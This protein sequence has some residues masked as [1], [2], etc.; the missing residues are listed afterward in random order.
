MNIKSYDCRIK[1]ILY[2]YLVLNGGGEFSM[3]L[4]EIFSSKKKFYLHKLNELGASNDGFLEYLNIM[5]ED[6]QKKPNLIRIYDDIKIQIFNT[7][8]NLI[9]NNIEIE[10]KLSLINDLIYITN[11]IYENLEETSKELESYEK[12]IF[13]NSTSLVVDI[14]ESY[15]FSFIEKDITVLEIIHTL[16]LNLN[17]MAET[18]NSVEELFKFGRGKY[19]V[20]NLQENI[21]KSIENIILNKPN[22]ERIGY[23][24]R[25]DIFSSI[26]N[27]IFSKIYQNISQYDLEVIFLLIKINHKNQAVLDYIKSINEQSTFNF[28]Y[29]NLIN[30]FYEE[31]ID[32]YI[33]FVNHPLNSNDI[34][35]Y[36]KNI[37][38]LITK[39]WNNNYNVLE[40]IF[41][42]NDIEKIISKNEQREIKT[43]IGNLKH[44]FTVSNE[45]EKQSNIVGQVENIANEALHKATVA[46]QEANLA[47]T[48]AYKAINEANLA[49][50]KSDSA[51]ST[52][53]NAEYYARNK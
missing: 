36:A 31:N 41:F 3:G 49:Q 43:Q 10:H 39:Y 11:E 29:D 16:E 35:Y 45:L 17:Y 22:I 14:L 53:K 51:I 52:A 18:P 1:I 50:S 5:L 38:N 24:L 21:Y 15:E 23:L 30:S 32:C 46:E 47:T 25:N 48:N 26:S 7:L 19:E 37:E 34:F 40:K 4:F 27:K 42:I 13:K 12:F 44:Q 2:K 20:P 28:F 8:S 6:I 33:E 9:K